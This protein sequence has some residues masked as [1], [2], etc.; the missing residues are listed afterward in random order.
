MPELQVG[1]G[2]Q[3]AALDFGE[4]APDPVRLA[5]PNREVQAV[6]PHV[7]LRADRLG[8]SL[9]RLTVVAPLRRRRRKEQS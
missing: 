8:V 7:T 3:G 1:V 6:A 5:H 9:T 2:E 4:P